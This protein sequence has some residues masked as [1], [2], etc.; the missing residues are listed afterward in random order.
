MTY[1]VCPKCGVEQKLT[2][3]HIKPVRHFGKGR[4]NP[5]VLLIC[6]ACHDDLEKLIP[7]KR[8]PRKFYYRIVREFLKGGVMYDSNVSANQ[9]H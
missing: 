9:R 7:H 3:H 4:H 1:G 6:R 5:N 8:Q 2:K